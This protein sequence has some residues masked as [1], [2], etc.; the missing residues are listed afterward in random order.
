L[1]LKEKAVYL[2][3][4]YRNLKREDEAEVVGQMFQKH[5]RR[6]MEKEK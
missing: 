1:V 6:E 5:W 4:Y 2:L 3:V